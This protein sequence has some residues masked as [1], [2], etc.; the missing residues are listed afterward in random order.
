MGLEFYPRFFGSR[1]SGID[2]K[3]IKTRNETPP[4]NQEKKRQTNKDFS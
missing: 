1:A 2:E 4:Q 3:K